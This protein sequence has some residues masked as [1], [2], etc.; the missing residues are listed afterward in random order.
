MRGAGI[1]RTSPL[2]ALA[3]FALAGCVTHGVVAPRAVAQA[4]TPPTHAWR[5]AFTVD[6]G[7]TTLRATVCFDGASPELLV[8]GGNAAWD[9]L[10][11]AVYLA[12]G[13]IVPLPHDA[14]GIS[15]AGVPPNACVRYEAALDLPLG[16]P[17][18]LGLRT[19]EGGVV[20]SSNLWLWYPATRDTAAEVT[21]RFELPP[22]IHVSVPWPTT[23]A[24]PSAL[25]PTYR[26]DATVFSRE[27]Y[28]GLGH[29]PVG[30]VSL[31]GGTLSVARFGPLLTPGAPD[32]RPWLEASGAIVTGLYG[33]FPAQRAQILMVG[34]SD[35]REP[36]PFAFTSHAGDDAV[37]FLVDARGTQAAL[38]GDS[39]AVHEFVHLGQPVMPD[40]ALWLDEG[41]A[42][43]FE[44]VLRA[45]AGQIDARTVW[46]YLDAGFGRGR[47]DRTGRTLTE[48]SA[49]LHVDNH[50]GRVYWAG[51]AIALLGDVAL[52]SDTAHP[53]TLD[54]VA[55]A[56]ARCCRDRSR[57]WTLDEILSEMDRAAGRA[58]FVPLARRYAH[59][60][61]FPDVEETYRALGVRVRDGRVDFDPRAPL[62]AVREAIT[63]P[64]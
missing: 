41:L 33:T 1:F 16:R 53:R 11:G 20:A 13:T 63:A 43:Y 23:E 32:P 51:A 28:L 61:D 50:F 27:G 36:V 48:D 10:R 9:H 44:R 47:A 39:T 17:S 19:A 56:L 55:R 25:A 26:L 52:R 54:D 31:P 42:V 57:V 3:P 4:P 40:E 30:A 5:Y 46:A 12:P 37:L 8:A 15:L 45:R 49:A 2:R 34:Q 38:G 60:S 21:A 59:A 7:V 14:D 29:D 58:V 62:A 22:G 24:A 6:P 35:A 18:F 64:R